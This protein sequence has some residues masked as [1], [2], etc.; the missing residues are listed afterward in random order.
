MTTHHSN[1]SAILALAGAGG[2]L[3]TTLAAGN[4]T[5]GSDILISSGDALAAEDNPAGAGFLLEIRGSDAGGAGPDDGGDINLIPGSG[6]GGGADGVVNVNGD[7]HVTGSL[8]LSN[9]ISGSGSPEGSV[10]A[11]IGAVYQREDG[12]AGNTLYFKQADNGLNT[13]W[14]PAGPRVRD[15]EVADGTATEFTT[16]RPVFEPATGLEQVGN[17]LVFWNGI[18][19]REG[20]DYS[21]TYIAGVEARVDFNPLVPPNEDMI[22][23]EYLPE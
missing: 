21:V 14:V 1:F 4:T 23:L 11:D 6:I 20:V 5:D 17:L 2:D 16:S 3:A 18:L 12:G 15:D 19:Q 9:L 10:V 8:V 22:T 13:G 7:L